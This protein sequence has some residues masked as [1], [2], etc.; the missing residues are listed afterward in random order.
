[1][2]IKIPKE[3]SIKEYTVKNVVNDNKQYDLT[4]IVPCYNVEKYICNC[5]KS[6]L[7]QKTKYSFEVIC[8]NDGSTDNTKQILE[9][10]SK[11]DSRIKIYNQKNMGISCSRNNGLSLAN[12][13]YVSF[14]DSDDFLEE[15]F[16]EKMMNSTNGKKIDFVKCGYIKNYINNNKRIY[17]KGKS[18]EASY[19]KLN[20]LIPK[21]NGYIWGAV[22]KKEIFK[23]IVFPPNYWFEDMITRMLILRRCN[24]FKYIKDCLYNYSVR[25]NSATKTQG[26]G[27]NIRNI[28]QLYL[29][30]QIYK[31]SNKL[32]I[33]NDKTFYKLII[34]ELGPMLYARIRAFDKKVQKNIFEL[35]CE[36]WKKQINQ[37]NYK[38]NIY[39]KIYIYSF[40]NRNFLIW[41]YNSNIIQIFRKIKF[42]IIH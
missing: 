6:I 24:T 36:I 27:Q 32:G 3:Y 14:V 26:K 11:K 4:I 35:T 2:S 33:K 30:S 19:D 38:F 41:K 28:D 23:D 12:G 20:V 22:I 31:Y 9:K 25:E 1:M 7:N 34:D 39:E 16:I 29:V 18:I 40:Y 21:I 5:L 13:E 15:D 17:F 42:F 8:I 37:E 10:F